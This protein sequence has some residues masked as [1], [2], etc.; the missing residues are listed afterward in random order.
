MYNSNTYTYVHVCKHTHVHCPPH[1]C[2]VPTTNMEVDMLNTTQGRA[3]LVRQVHIFV[4][5][6]GGKDVDTKGEQRLREQEGQET[7]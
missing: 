1:T 6:A 4:D 7:D 5:V 2:T 3:D